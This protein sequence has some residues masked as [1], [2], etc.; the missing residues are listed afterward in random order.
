MQGPPLGQAMCD[1]HRDV[2]RVVE[3]VHELHPHVL[4]AAGRRVM[5]ERHVELTRAQAR[6]R[7]DGVGHDDR[8]F[9]RR[10]ARAKRSDRRRHDRRC[11]RRERRQA[12]APAVEVRECAQLGFRVS[13]CHEDGLGARHQEAPGIGEDGSMG[14]ASHH[15]ESDLCLERR[16]RRDTAGCV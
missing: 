1:G 7:V 12:Q 10:V 8:Q 6:Q 14:Y 15:G 11:R 2:H 13:E 4:G 5:G 3:Q 9:D 16:D